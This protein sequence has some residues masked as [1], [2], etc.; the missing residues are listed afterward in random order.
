MQLEEFYAENQAG[1]S[2]AG[3]GENGT[4]FAQHHQQQEHHPQHEGF[5]QPLDCNSNLQI[6]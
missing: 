2:W 4:S 5:F 1:P 3:G 6:G